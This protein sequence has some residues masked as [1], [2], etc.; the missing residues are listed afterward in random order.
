VV[1]LLRRLSLDPRGE[2]PDGPGASRCSHASKLQPGRRHLRLGQ[3]S[4]MA[5]ASSDAA[6]RSL[7]TALPPPDR[8]RDTWTVLYGRADELGRIDRLLGTARAGF[9]AALCVGGG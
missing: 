8:F 4:R 1:V 5:K 2:R 9:S 3:L 7:A 6:G